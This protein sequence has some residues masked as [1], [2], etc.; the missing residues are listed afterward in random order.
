MR[1]IYKYEFGANGILIVPHGKVVLVAQQNDSELPTVWVEHER[2]TDQR[3]ALHMYP[4]GQPI[5]VRHKHVGSAV[6]GRFVWH[7]YAG[8]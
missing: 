4:T 8:G 3:M 5:D 2:V 1:T 7:V 6:C